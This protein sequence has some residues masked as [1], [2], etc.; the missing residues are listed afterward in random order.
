MRTS[1]LTSSFALLILTTIHTASAT[2][3]CNGKNVSPQFSYCYTTATRTCVPIDPNN[4]TAPIGSYL[5]MFVNSSLAQ[6]I[7]PSETI[8]TVLGLR[9]VGFS[10]DHPS[11]ILSGTQPADFQWSIAGDNITSMA[12]QGIQWPNRIAR[13][14]TDRNLTPTDPSSLV[15]VY[16]GLLEDIQTW[17]WSSSANASSVHVAFNGDRDVT[18]SMWMPQQDAR[19]SYLNGEWYHAPRGD[20]NATTS[21]DWLLLFGK[22]KMCAYGRLTYSPRENGTV[23]TRGLG[24]P[25]ALVAAP[26][27]NLTSSFALLILTTIHT[28]S[29]SATC[30]GKN[31]SPQISYCY[32]TATRTCVPIDP[33]NATAPIGS[34]LTMFVNSSLAQSIDPSE[35]IDTEVGLRSLGSSDDRPSIILSGTQPVDFQWSIAGD[36]ITNFGME[37]IQWPNRIARY[38]TDRNLTLT[39]PSSLVPVYG[40]LLEDMQASGYSYANESSVYV[41]FN[42]DRDVTPAM[43]MPLQD[44]R[45]AYLDGQW[46]H[47]PKGN[48][49]A[50]TCARTGG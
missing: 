25:P 14:R 27:A 23:A 7:D 46:Y 1:N 47:A 50:T 6:S 31:V 5:T 30:N 26:L 48:E 22:S 33:N 49:T 10:D 18:P 35:T 21:V 45:T 9:S 16:G 39:D 24:S 42:G 44:A 17:G 37:G 29:A 8:G 11:F 38:R 12:I 4:A 41:A 19:S 43:W 20:E 3:T 15:P 32:T 34:Y 28:A 36:S 13:Y 2:A 40:V